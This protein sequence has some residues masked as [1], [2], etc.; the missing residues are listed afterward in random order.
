MVSSLS[1]GRTSDAKPPL[2]EKL[3]D[4]RGSWRLGRPTWTPRS[5]RVVGV[6][7][8]VMHHFL[9]PWAGRRQRAGEQAEA[10]WDHRHQEALRRGKH[11][12][13]AE[14]IDEPR[15]RSFPTEKLESFVARPSC[16]GRVLPDGEADSATAVSMGRRPPTANSH[17]AGDGDVG[18]V[19]CGLSRCRRSPS[20]PTAQ[21]QI[22]RWRLGSCG[23]RSSFRGG[24]EVAGPAR[25]WVHSRRRYC[26]R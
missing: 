13:D 10:D 21:A 18:A 24:V 8:T 6:R 9:A 1:P 7:P 25:R 2:S 12:R 14:L 26:V 19:D 20:A 15:P 17:S 23:C 22:R 4:R 3:A 11:D 16:S 5:Q